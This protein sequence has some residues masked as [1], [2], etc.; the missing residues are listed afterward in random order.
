MRARAQPGRSVSAPQW[1]CL[2]PSH[3]LSSRV[4]CLLAGLPW[5]AGDRRGG[6][7]GGGTSP[8][9]RAPSRTPPSQTR[10]SRAFARPVWTTSSFS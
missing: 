3:L 8:P 6:R 5:C 7:G 4:P 9:R 2:L 10:L 1:L